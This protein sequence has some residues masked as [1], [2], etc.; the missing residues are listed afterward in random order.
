MLHTIL[1]KMLTVGISSWIAALNDD[2]LKLCK[3]VQYEADA[4]P[5]GSGCGKGN[6]PTKLVRRKVRGD[7]REVLYERGGLAEEEMKLAER[8]IDNCD[9]PKVCHYEARMCSAPNEITVVMAGA[10][11][12]YANRLNIAISLDKEGDDFPCEE[13]TAAL[14]AATVLLAPKLIGADAVEG[15]ELEAIC[16]AIKDPKSIIEN[17]TG[18]NP[19][20]RGIR[21]APK[22]VPVF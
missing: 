3:D 9:P 5:T 10:G 11:N 18:T 7:T 4:D 12:P 16:G 13:I 22:A 6:I 2:T 17:L 1:E 8:Y 15:I 20:R 19:T 21:R 14:T